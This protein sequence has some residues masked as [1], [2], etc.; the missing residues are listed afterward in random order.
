VAAASIAQQGFRLPA[1][2]A[3]GDF[4]GKGLRV[5]YTQEQREAASEHQGS[6]LMFGQ[7]IYVSKDLEKATRFAQ[8]AVILCQ[9]APGKE[10]TARQAQHGLTMAQ[11]QGQGYDSVRALAGCQ[12]S[13]GCRFE[14]S[15]LYHED[16]VLP[17]HVVHFR[18]VKS[19][20]ASVVAQPLSVENRVQALDHSV[21]NLLDQLVFNATAT[22]GDERRIQA[23]KTLGDIAR[24][25]QQKGIARFL[26]DR[27]LTSAL[28]SC[29]KSPNEALQFEAL[30]A[31]WNFSFNDPNAQAITMQNLG[32][33]FV[34]SLL[35]SPNESLRLRATGL[36]WNLTQHCQN[37][38]QVFVEAGV[39]E[40]L[41]GS[42]QKAVS[43]ITA[44]ASPPWG[45]AQLLFGGLANIALSC[46]ADVRR[47]ECI[48]R[49]GELMI[50]MD[51]ITPPAVQQQ[52]TRLVCNL[53]SDGN[54]DPEW[55]EKGFSYR[56]SA[57][58]DVLEIAIEA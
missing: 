56:T 49:A 19:C 23:C 43:E 46:G 57:P 8:G 41:G 27:K 54:V 6:M 31:W 4:V 18:L 36:V 38:R 12:E 39:L 21:D 20:G 29:A 45:V 34:C 51:L 24:D 42:L 1:A 48:V 30:R 13:G 40:K 10:M 26:K 33:A 15:A 5:Y 2:D 14:E 25:D 11:V 22:N 9:C 37:S 35:Q 17:T 47:H 3:D 58:R 44:S 53:I 7:G 55:Q 52:A 28:A 50:G 16:Q 32:V